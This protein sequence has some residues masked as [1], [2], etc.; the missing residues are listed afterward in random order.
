VLIFLADIGIGLVVLIN[1]QIFRQMGRVNMAG[2]LALGVTLFVCV[3]SVAANMYLWPLLVTVDAPLPRLAKVAVKLVLLHPLW[4]VF[5]ALLSAV[6]LLVLFV[7][8]GF[9]VLL[10][11]FSTCALLA[12]W[13]AWRV[14]GKF[15]T[16]EE[17]DL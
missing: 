11:A 9:V 17:L 12:S 10:G 6:P 13:G 4:S 8:P 1:V 7:L 15:I 2:L 3:V 14:L 5:A 16:V